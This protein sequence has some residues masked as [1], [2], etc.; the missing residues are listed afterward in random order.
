MNYLSLSVANCRWYF[1]LCGSLP[2]FGLLSV[3][4][5]IRDVSPRTVFELA[6]CSSTVSVSSAN[7][8]HNGTSWENAL[9]VDPA[10]YTSATVQSN[11]KVGPSCRRYAHNTTKCRWNNFVN[12]HN[13]REIRENL[14]SRNLC[15]S[16]LSA[17]WCM[18]S[19]LAHMHRVHV[20]VYSSYQQH[21]HLCTSG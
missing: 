17:C 14:G 5:Q 18:Q 2:H 13:S 10:A 15:F 11:P 3:R 19:E 7:M 6:E 8:A 21:E 9:I 4:F 16:G 12:N 1:V 20:Y